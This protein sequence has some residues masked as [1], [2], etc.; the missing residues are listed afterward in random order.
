MN[1]FGATY[2]LFRYA[3]RS[4]K[5]SS[6]F[7]S[8]PH[9]LLILIFSFLFFFYSYLLLIF[10]I[11]TVFINFFYHNLLF[12]HLF[13]NLNPFK[14]W[15]VTYMQRYYDLLEKRKKLPVWLQ[16]EEFLKQFKSKQILI[17]VGESGCGKSSQVSF[18]ILICD[19]LVNSVIFFWT[20]KGKS[21]GYRLDFFF[22]P[23]LFYG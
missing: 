18:K 17:L 13:I 10:N 20:S 7:I 11:L 14:L 19:L 15:L 9:F 8:V 3:R 12:L 5:I 4:M 16:K 21:N 2:K 6:I 22:F 23:F 1:T